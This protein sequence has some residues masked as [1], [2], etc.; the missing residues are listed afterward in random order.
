MA[1]LKSTVF[2]ELY[3]SITDEELN[4]V[5]IAMPGWEEEHHVSI[6]TREEAIKSLR[7]IANW[8]EEEK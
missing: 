7:E 3:V 6:S 2:G 1:T 4:E 5:V 8:L